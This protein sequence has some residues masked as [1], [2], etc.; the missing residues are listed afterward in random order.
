[1]TPEEIRAAATARKAAAARKSAQQQRPDPL[2]LM[3]QAPAGQGAASNSLS[4]NV[5]DPVE[6]DP[7]AVTT[8]LDNVVGLDNGVMSTGEKIATALNVGGE[9]LTLGLVGDEAA[10]LTDAA[11]GR[12]TYD[13]RLAV[14]RRQEE[15]FRE[16]NPKSAFLAEVAPAL[17]PG[18]GGAKA[19]QVLGKGVNRVAAGAGLGAASGAVYGFAEGEGAEGRLANSAATMVLGG[20]FGA[21]AP[22]VIDGLKGI[23]K[24]VSNA[25]KKSQERPTISALKATKN[26][27]YKAVDS[28]G[29]TF[30]PDDM[31]G[32]SARVSQVFDD[33][34]FVEETDNASRAVLKILERRKDKPTTLSQLDS[35]RQNLWKRYSGAQDQ[36][37]ILDA[38][39]EIDALI[40]SKAGASDLMAVARAANARY[41]KSKL[42]EDA[43][44][45][46]RDQTAS[47]GS[48]GNV[49]NKY[50]QAVTAII[51]DPKRAK[52]FSDAEIGVMREFVTGTTKENLQ[53]LVGKL[54]PSGNG[55]MMALHVVGGMASQGATLPLMVAGSG[56]K[57]MA[58]KN[59]MRGASR[60]Q[61][62]VAGFVPP[63]PPAPQLNVLSGSAITGS[64]P[65]LE[66][67]PQAIQNKLRSLQ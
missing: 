13:E 18:A 60:L 42:L 67:A 1:M 54:S 26:Q 65:A 61:D 50:R 28:S 37:V 9:S 66:R 38:I 56:A 4:I 53:R 10:A 15:Q 63:A 22:K 62:V 24:A 51:N 64:T 11:M 43:F 3:R 12:G 52:F 41:S 48:G 6:G 25:F 23:P 21:A 27:A 57:S 34:N 59:A 49:V 7:T 46:A 20:V 44:Q 39:S 32:L 16:E 58:E 17:I 5:F 19:V 35:I 8:V 31:A 2:E 30:S 45:K 40:D 36:P 33:N 29:E 55:L 47:T 14:R